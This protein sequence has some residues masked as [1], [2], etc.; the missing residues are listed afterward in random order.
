MKKP[1]LVYKSQ[2]LSRVLEVNVNGKNFVT[3]AYFPAISSYKIKIP[4]DKLVYLL[5]S[6]SYPRAL[7]SAYDLFHAEKSKRKTLLTAI[8]TF[9]DKGFLFLDSGV[10]ESSWRVDQKWNLKSYRNL[11]SQVECDFYSSFDFLPTK[12][13]DKI[14]KEFKRRTFKNILAS[15][16]VSQKSMFV[17]I[18][19]G[20]NP[21]QLISILTKFVKTHP[22][23][24]G[25]IAITERDCGMSFLEKAKTIVTIR[26]ILDKNDNQNLLHLLGCGN[27]LSM[28][29]FSYCGVD[30]FD[31]LDWVE[32]II[33]R[34]SLKINDFSQLEL[35]YCD[36]PICSGIERDY[37]EKALLHNL[38]FYQDF[39]MQIQSLIKN[40]D[41][42]RFLRERMHVD[43]RI[44][45][46]I[47]KF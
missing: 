42:S 20:L 28:L 19:H 18:L 14:D 25:T 44:L 15:H 47:D 45:E 29:F 11:V 7:V 35:L 27:P 31:S 32:H 3:P 46:K 36:C 40:N 1:D 38:L 41:I 5:V 33:D 10:Y 6:Y 43:K 39:M 2:K 9:R 23:L 26:K 13:N 37:T 4:F 24:S 22:D 8:S 16:N 21:N 12:A 17:P 34:N 30:T